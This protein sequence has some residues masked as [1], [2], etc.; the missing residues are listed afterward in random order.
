MGTTPTVPNGTATIT[1]SINGYTVTTPKSV[2]AVVSGTSFNVYIGDRAD[3]CSVLQKGASPS[4]TTF[5]TFGSAAGMGPHTFPAGAYTYPS[6][7]GSGGG[8]GGGTGG[9]M[10]GGGNGGGGGTG[11]GGAGMGTRTALI[12]T[13][14]PSCGLTGYNQA[15]TGS[16]T[17]KAPVDT[18]AKTID[19]SFDIT[20]DVTT[21]KGTFTGTFSAAVC[22]NAK[23]IPLNAVACD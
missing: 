3:L 2:V 16:F 14:D 1:G 5:L 7:A 4:A 15:S 18:T 19:G 22:P 12:A 9:G 10:G 20:F 13:S 17:L 11:G 8:T 23:D 21:Q 6:G